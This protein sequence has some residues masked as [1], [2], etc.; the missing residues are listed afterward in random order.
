MKRSAAITGV[1]PIRIPATRIM[2]VAERY[3]NIMPS[4]QGGGPKL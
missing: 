4:F 2:S 3:L 1:N